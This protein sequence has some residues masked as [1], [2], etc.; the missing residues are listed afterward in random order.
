MR[1]NHG[2]FLVRVLSSSRDIDHACVE[3]CTSAAKPPRNERNKLDAS[4]FA[5]VPLVRFSI[6]G[7]SF[8]LGECISHSS[9]QFILSRPLPRSLA[10]LRRYPPIRRFPLPPPAFITSFSAGRRRGR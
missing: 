2:S 9:D 10:A 1:D 4:A 7:K 5:S 3:A 6:S 8:V